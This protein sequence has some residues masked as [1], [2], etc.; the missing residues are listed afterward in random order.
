MGNAKPPLVPASPLVG[1]ARELQRDQLGTYQRAMTLFGGQP[2]RFRIGPPWVGF[3]FYTVFRPD[4]ARQV[5]ATDAARYDKGV[6]V[7]DEFKRVIG[8][9]LITSDGER[10]RRDRRIVAPIFTRRRVASYTAAMASAAARVV[11]RWEPVASNGG[12][13]VDLH[14]DAIHY[15]LDVLGRTVFGDDVESMAALL[16][17]TVPGLSEYAT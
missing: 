17:D 11:A 8:N 10:W 5:L 14:D 7:I 6:P 3:E 15:T 2:V 1:S 9:G 13:F 4:D 12:G 16:S